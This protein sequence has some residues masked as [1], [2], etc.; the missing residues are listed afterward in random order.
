MAEDLSFLVARSGFGACWLTRCGNGD[1]LSCDGG[2]KF[3]NEVIIWKLPRA[4]GLAR[5][6][7]CAE[8]VEAVQTLVE[9]RVG[10]SKVV[11]AVRLE[12]DMEIG[13]S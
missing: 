9:V 12:A 11:R 7:F 1:G 10:G 8:D 3:A 13:S 4:F 5:S 2:S 6:A